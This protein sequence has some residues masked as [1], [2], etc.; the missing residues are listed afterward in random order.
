MLHQNFL[1][2]TLGLVAQS[3]QEHARAPPPS[4]PPPLRLVASLVHPSASTIQPRS[5]PCA[6]RRSPPHL[7]LPRLAHRPAPLPPTPAPFLPLCLSFASAQQ[8]DD[9][10]GGQPSAVA[11][12]RAS[13]GDRCPRAHA[14]RR[15]RLR[16]AADGVRRCCSCCNA[17]DE[18]STRDRTATEIRIFIKYCFCGTKSAFVDLRSAANSWLLVLLVQL[19]HAC[20]QPH[21]CPARWKCELALRPR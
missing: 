7:A 9:S 5:L 6:R 18:A 14:V 11:T 15:C 12:A 10:G 17:K 4:N 2:W 21:R 16:L 3:H 20:D 1:V 19:L 13:A 8:E